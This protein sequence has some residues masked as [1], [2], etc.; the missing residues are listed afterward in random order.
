MARDDKAIA[1]ANNPRTVVT[2]P[3]PSDSRPPTFPATATAPT[4]ASL[5]AAPGSLAARADVQAFI[6]QMAAQHGFSQTE[7]SALFSRAH[8][9][10]DIVALI[11]RPAEGK[12]WYA[13]RRIFLTAARI[14]GGVS[15]WRANRDALARAEQVYGVPAEIIVAIIGVETSYGGNM[16]KYRVLE[17]LATLAF[18]YPKRADFFRKELENYLVLTR[19][20]GIDPLSL[21]GSY[22]GAMGLG[23][24]MPSSFLSYAVDFDGDRRRNLWTNPRD[25]IGSV[26]NYLSGHQWRRGGPIATPARVN[27]GQYPVLVDR[28]LRPPDRPVSELNR[29][30]V[31]PVVSVAGNQPALLLEYEG[32]G[33][34]EYWL[35]FD[36]FYVITRYNHSQLYAMAVYQLG[37]EIRGRI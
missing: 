8:A 11:S 19:D 1:S 3:T 24:F 30:G 31:Y 9:Q 36:N 4:V 32:D 29:Q 34:M 20:E 23:Q 37:Q 26:A 27:G 33:G 17:A 15:F 18:D 21:Q 14:Q 25:A 2:P 28:K 7:L 35:G 6:R 13:Y 5:P 10:P 22:A 12:P 16:G